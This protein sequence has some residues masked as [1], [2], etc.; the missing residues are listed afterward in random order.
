MRVL[1]YE[2]INTYA[3]EKWQFLE[4]RV[5]FGP[6]MLKYAQTPTYHTTTSAHKMHS[7]SM[8]TLRKSLLAAYSVKSTKNP[9]KSLPLRGI[10][11]AWCFSALFLDI[12]TTRCRCS[13]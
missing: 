4:K 2:R 13:G 10:H 12:E 9:E 11:A 1:I 5:L 7:K 6:L 8:R 3:A